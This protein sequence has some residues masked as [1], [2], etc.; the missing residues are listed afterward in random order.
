MALDSFLAPLHQVSIKNR[1]VIE[2]AFF[3]FEVALVG[4]WIVGGFI[5]FSNPDNAFSLYEV[6]TKF[7]IVSLVLYL[8]TLVPGI[9][10]R[11][12]VLPLLGVLLQTYRRHFGIS[13]FLSAYLHM[14][15]TTT[16]P[17]L[18]TN[19]LPVI[20]GTPAIWGFIAFVLLL[21]LWLTSNDVSQKRL[22]KKW[23]ML[24]RLTY[25]AL[26]FIFLHQVF[27]NY[28]WIIPLGIAIILEIISWL[29]F[30]KRK[31]AIA[32]VQTQE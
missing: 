21:P 3:W 13:M 18:A 23:K 25:A 22:G 28:I 4:L 26:F 12:K 19:R 20:V 6:G 16:L 27:F 32:P 24:H 5:I 2:S 15:F 31:A 14:S 8:V 7:G 29:V 1:S 9:L 17:A 11:L 10:S 30:W